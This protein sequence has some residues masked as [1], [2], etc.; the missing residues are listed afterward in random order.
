M[1]HA[2]SGSSRL[3]PEATIGAKTK[4]KSKTVA[5]LSSAT[6]AGN[7]VKVMAKT[8]TLRAGEENMAA[9]TDST[10]IPEA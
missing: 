9:R 4:I 3:W 5:S 10:L 6:D 2:T 7:R 1:G 8:T